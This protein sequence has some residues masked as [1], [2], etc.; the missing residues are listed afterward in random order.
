MRAA[1]EEPPATYNKEFGYSRKDIIIIGVGLIALG[2]ASYYGLQAAGVEAGMAGNFVQLAIF[3][4]IC[5][6]WVSTYVYRVATKVWCS[7]RQPG[8]PWVRPMHTRPACGRVCPGAT[9][10]DSNTEVIHPIHP[11]T[12]HVCA[13]NDVCEAAGAI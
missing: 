4:G 3:L 5:V 6:F 2:Y 1:P 12:H 10:M 8:A 9:Y 13:A 11:P 7:K